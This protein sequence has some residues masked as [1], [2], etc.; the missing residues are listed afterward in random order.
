MD[1]SLQILISSE[2]LIEFNTGKQTEKLLKMELRIKQTS[3]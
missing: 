3:N 2:R 1:I